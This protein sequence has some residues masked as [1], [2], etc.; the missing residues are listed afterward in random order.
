M[1]R[2]RRTVVG[3]VRDIVLAD[4]VVDSEHFPQDLKH[5]YWLDIMEC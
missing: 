4:K 5:I 2:E 3:W 1:G